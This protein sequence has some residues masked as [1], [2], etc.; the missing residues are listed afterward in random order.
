VNLEYLPEKIAGT[1]LYNPGNN[2]KE[3][4]IREMLKKLWAKYNY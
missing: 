3:N 2:Q 1:A 4:T